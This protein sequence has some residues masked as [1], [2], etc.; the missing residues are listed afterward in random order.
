MLNI[1][2]FRTLDYKRDLTLE[3]QEELRLT[4]KLNL[5]CSDVFFESKLRSDHFGSLQELEELDIEHCKIRV[6]PPRAFVGLSNLHSLSIETH[7]RDWSEVLLHIDYEAFVGL[8]RL[9]QIKLSNNN[10]LSIPAQLWCPMSDLRTIEL[11]NNQL[12]NLEDLGLSTAGG[13]G[14]AGAEQCSVSVT[15]LELSGNRLT[16]LTPGSLGAA[17]RLE[18]LIVRDNEVSV[19]DRMTFHGLATLTTVDLR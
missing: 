1:F 14:S 13:V 12:V 19:L 15:K 8:N 11:N 7:N 5:T 3:H 9:K 10:I 6:L 2:C 4:S 16:T 17:T 18:T